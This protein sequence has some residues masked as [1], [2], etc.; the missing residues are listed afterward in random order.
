MLHNPMYSVDVSGDSRFPID[1]DRVRR[2]VAKVLTK[3]GVEGA[4]AVSVRIVGD[5]KMRQLN[6]RF[7]KKKG[8]ADV[9]SFATEELDSGRSSGSLN[10][11]GFVYPEQEAFPLGDVVISYPRARLAAAERDVFVD[12]EIETLVEHG[13]KNLLGRNP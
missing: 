10:G 2:T 8:T 13:V 11:A 7:R 12:D 9:L 4:T 6:Q 1:R 3:F 5:R